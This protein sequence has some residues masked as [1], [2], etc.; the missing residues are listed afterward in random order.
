MESALL[1]EIQP[2]GTSA[3]GPMVPERFRVAERRQETADTW[4]LELQP[5]DRAGGFVF[6][7]GQF[8][9]LYAF[10][11]G[12]V[13]ISISGDPR[14]SERLVHT[15]RAVGAAS[16]AICR[17]APGKV[18]GVRGPFGSHW[19]LESAD[20]RDVVI[21]AGGIG[22]A[23]LRPVVYEVLSARDRFGRA[24]LLYGGRE[25][26]QL[27]YAAELEEW[28]SR[29]LEVEVTVDIAPA[30]WHGR[31]GVVPTLI[32][33]A[34]FDPEAAVAF[35]CGPEAMI[36]FSAEALT[37][38]GVAPDRVYVSMERNMKCAV[39]H[40][41]HCQLGPTFVCRDGPVFT[42]ER[43]RAAFALREL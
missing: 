31:V 32:E 3:P 18:L 37:E 30:R 1:P 19:P 28:R 14:L 29:G 13:P 17:T 2:A 21:V 4:T 6:L 7:P 43:M 38:R 27:L 8:T 12:E 25:P 9:M 20:A 15:V 22:L 42:F 26:E 23:P 11:A 39:G 36:R 41:G 5:L 10:G 40:C 16:G 24:L 34:R 33:R 35:V